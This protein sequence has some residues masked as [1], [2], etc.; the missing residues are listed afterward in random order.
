MELEWFLTHVDVHHT[1]SKM[2]GCDSCEAHHIVYRTKLPVTRERLESLCAHMTTFSDLVRRGTLKLM[3]CPRCNG[4]WYTSQEGEG[5]CCED[6][7]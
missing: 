5:V 6:C 3:V 4:S 1:L 2:A 7:R